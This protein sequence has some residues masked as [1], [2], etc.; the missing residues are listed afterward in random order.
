MRYF[1]CHFLCHFSCHFL[2][3]FLSYFL[4]YFQFRSGTHKMHIV[5]AMFIKH[6]RLKFYWN[7]FHVSSRALQFFLLIRI[8]FVICCLS[9][10]WLEVLCVCVWDT[11]KNAILLHNAKNLHTVS[12]VRLY[13]VCIG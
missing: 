10:F 13:R 7:F 6:L 2:C 9:K 4:C 5:R 8:I 1:L 3:H 11:M 12:F